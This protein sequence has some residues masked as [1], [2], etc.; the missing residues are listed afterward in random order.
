MGQG[1][2]SAKLS[3]FLGVGILCLLT[4]TN[5]TLGA[6]YTVGGAGGWAFNVNNWSTGKPFKAGDMLGQILFY[7]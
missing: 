3:L 4:L 1:N 7:I 6:I 5:P 2:G